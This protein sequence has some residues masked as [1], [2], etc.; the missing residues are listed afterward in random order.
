MKSH[1]VP[2]AIISLG[3]MTRLQ[4]DLI[5][6]RT[7]PDGEFKWILH[8]RDHFTKY[9]WVYALTRK[10][11]RQVAENLVQL[12]F[13]FGPCK[14]LQS[15]NG[16]EFTAQIIKDLKIMWPGLVILNGRPRHP[17]S[18]GLVERGNSTLCDIL[19]K[20]MQDRD[21]SHWVT[22]LLPAI[23]SMNTSLAQ[24]IK[25]TPFEVVFGQKPRLNMT[26]WQSIADQGIE[27]EDDLPPSIRKQ[28]EET[29]DAD[30]TKD[31]G[32]I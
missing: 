5:D 7:R 22:C 30:V 4:I 8:C 3:F 10:E 32:K 28:L 31:E 25:H 15:D 11:A 1:V 12:F 16:K 26:L 13:Q 19:G 20:F 14:I 23:Y 29:P 9:S 18:Q 6:M 24:G 27:D 17:Q 21:T 2:T